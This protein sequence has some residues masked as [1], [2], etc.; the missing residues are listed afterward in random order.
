M[1]RVMTDRGR[2]ISTVPRLG[3]FVAAARTVASRR[4]AFVV[5]VRSKTRDL[6]YLS[7][8]V[9]R[10]ALRPVIDRVFPLADVIDASKRLET[11]HARGKVVLRVEN[12]ER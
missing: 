6:A 5:V 2:Y 12:G 3:N 8:L 10:G 1:R 9:S 7:D 11:K 4:R